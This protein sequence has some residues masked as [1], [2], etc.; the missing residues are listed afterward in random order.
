MLPGVANEQSTTNVAG[1]P[2]QNWLAHVDY[3]LKEAAIMGLKV[4]ISPHSLNN[5]F[6]FLQDLVKYAFE[7]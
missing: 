3:Y 6:H 5:L 1:Y 4:F 2:E 7:V